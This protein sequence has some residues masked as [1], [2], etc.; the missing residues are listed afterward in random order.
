MVR[1]N[2]H[3]KTE[4]DVEV[5]ITKDDLIRLLH[6]AHDEGEPDITEY[7][8]DGE[9]VVLKYHSSDGHPIHIADEEYITLEWREVEER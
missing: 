8:D 6:I 1:I 4:R 7:P 3:E 5:Q 2:R 9:G